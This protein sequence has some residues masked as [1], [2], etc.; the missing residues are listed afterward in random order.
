[1]AVTIRAGRPEDGKA[2]QAIELSAGERFRDVGLGF[3]ADH[4]PASIDEL[5]AYA[6]DGR[7]WVAVDH[8]D[9]PVGYLLVDVVDGQAHVEQVSVLPD[10][11]GS[12]LGRAL[13][14]RARDQASNEGQ[15]ALTLTTFTDVEWNRPLYEHLGFRV[16]ADSEIGP[17][18][19]ALMAEEAAHGLDPASRVAM[20]REVT[21]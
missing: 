21:P 4:D 20:R 5:A 9:V 8:D 6:R 12:G 15:S 7:S 10:R 17:E 2:L 19:R 13:I 16:L 11:Q 1:M 3:V 14:G 18:L